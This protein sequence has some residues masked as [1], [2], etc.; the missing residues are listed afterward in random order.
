M[1]VFS[2]PFEFILFALTLL[3]VAL[4]HTRVLTVAL[5]GLAAIV[6][7]LSVIDLTD[8]AGFIAIVHHVFTE[9]IELANLFLL[10]TG[11]ALISDNFER[12]HLPDAMPR[13]LPRSWV[14]GLVLL[15]LV[16]ALS[17]V[18]DNIAGALIGA[19][20]AR[21]VF[22]G[23]VHVGYLA[24][25][26]AA[27]NAGGAGSVIGDTTTTMMWI[28]GVSPL[29]VLHAFAGSFAAFAVFAPLA[30]LAQHRLQP[31]TDAQGAH[32]PVDWIRVASVVAVLA[33]A[34]TANVWV[35]LNAPSELEE[36][37]VFGVALWVGLALVSL[38]RPPHI[39]ALAPA[40]KSAVFL[41]ALVIAASLMPVEALPPPSAHSAFA[42]G[43]ISAVFDNIP[44]TAL[45]LSQ[46][47]YDW[48]VLAYAVGFGG[49]MLWFGSS[50][51]VAVANIFPEAKS[52]LAWLRA[53]WPVAAGYVVGFG[54]LIL[55]F[56]WR[57]H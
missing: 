32:V 14:A 7:Y 4:F 43:V 52:T 5:T 13:I 54:V 28:S 22:N 56:G 48:G 31:A 20:I 10:L 37:P 6:I 2:I 53:G 45:A 42:L 41:L 11:F 50:A 36:W 3:G 27:S 24:A 9:W 26:V 49:S 17:A 18:L 51:G 44:L 29:D 40:I 35:T 55:A 30:A 1:T 33:G 16:F 23:K 19:T 57:P 34:V 25:I 21:H 12:S 39:K 15:A 38:L 46:G 47:G 8:A